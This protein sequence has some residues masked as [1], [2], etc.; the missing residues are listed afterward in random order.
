MFRIYPNF[1]FFCST[2]TVKKEKGKLDIVSPSA[3]TNAFGPKSPRRACL[4]KRR[5]KSLAFA[6]AELTEACG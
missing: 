1:E 2:A 3:G 5:T 6:E 4:L